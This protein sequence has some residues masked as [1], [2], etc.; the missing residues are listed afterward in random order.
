MTVREAA[1]FSRIVTV[2]RK[3]QQ[4]VEIAGLGQSLLACLD[5]DLFPIFG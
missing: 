5:V 1:P 4:M 2:G 3:R